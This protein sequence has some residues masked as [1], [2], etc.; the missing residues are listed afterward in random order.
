MKKLMKKK[1]Y[2]FKKQYIKVGDFVSIICGNDK[3]KQGKVIGVLKEDQKIIVEGIN[4]RF[5]YLKPQ[6]QGDIGKI[7]QFY[8][9]IDIS[10]AKK[11]QN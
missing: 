8:A 4:L 5:R 7:K 2:K 3:S 6:R 11:L 9:P 1:F 10:N